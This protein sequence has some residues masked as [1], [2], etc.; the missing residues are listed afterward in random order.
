[1]T[2][3]GYHDGVPLYE[4]EMLTFGWDTGAGFAVEGYFQL[5]M[6]GISSVA[7]VAVNAANASGG[8]LSWYPV[9]RSP[10]TIGLAFYDYT[11]AT[12]TILTSGP[13]R[14]AGTWHH[15][16]MQI[17]STGYWALCCGLM[18]PCTHRGPRR[19]GPTGTARR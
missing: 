15:V 18:G 16:A 12:E 9:D 17:R 2:G 10:G 14:V 6:S 7:P 19:C 5:G 3:P 4:P 11:S 8:A 1:M 13:T